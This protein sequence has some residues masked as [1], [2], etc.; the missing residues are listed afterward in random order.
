LTSTTNNQIPSSPNQVSDGIN[1][2]IAG[3]NGKLKQIEI[4]LAVPKTIEHLLRDKNSEG[5]DILLGRIVAILQGVDDVQRQN[6]AIALAGTLEI[7][8]QEEE[9]QRM[10][11]LLPA[12]QQSLHI[13]ADNDVA[14]E[15]CITAVTK[16]AVHLIRMGQYSAPR[17]ILV[18]INGPATRAAA[19][20][21]F[22]KLAAQA[23]DE[24][25]LQ[26]VMD[27]LL[28]EYLHGKEKQ[29]EAGRL[30]VAFDLQATDFL[31]DRLSLSDSKT[32]RLKLLKLIENIGEPAKGA[33][34]MVLKQTTPWY[35]TRNI[36][37]LL[38]ET[39][40]L[41]CFQDVIPYLEHDDFRVKQEVL[42]AAAKIGGSTRKQFLLKALKTVPP[43]LTGHVISLLGDIPDDSLVV[44]LAELLDKGCI[45]QSKCGTE[46]Q[47]TICEA[48]GKIGSI[49]AV[50]ILKKIIAHNTLPGMDTEDEEKSPILQAAQDALQLIR[51]D[52][53]QKI[54]QTRV[55]KV[56]GLQMAADDVSAKEAAI[57]RIAMTGDKKKALRKLFDLIR[58]CAENKDFQNAERLR[59][60]LYEI[61]PMAI[62]A[63]IQ[64]AEV[65]ERA[66][67]GVAGPGFLH[68]W[69]DMRNELTRQ[70]FSAIYHE[71]K[72]RSLQAEEILIKQGT[73]NNELFFINHGSIKVSYKQDDRE[74]FVKSL[75]AGEIA[76]ENFFNASVWTVNLR[77]LTPSRVSILERS[78]FSRWQEEFPGLTGK[79]EAFYK[80]SDN[81]Q[82]LLIQKGLSRRQFERYQLSRKV[83]IQLTDRRGRVIGRGF[84][85]ELS[86]ISRG[87]LALLIGMAAQENSR[88]LLGRDIQ[89]LIPVGGKP[90]YLHVRGRVQAVH[91]STP[92]HNNFL[93]HIV[94]HDELNQEAL[95]TILG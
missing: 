54:H 40:S 92:Q 8:V 38:G 82:D 27:K 61:S 80:R 2:L 62:N 41:D 46:L 22:N 37:R 36:I 85:G 1:R 60:R 48:L 17:I 70:E 25:A 57:I 81:V 31:M 6:A 21:Q 14:I 73:K 64:S 49:K 86:D 68:I 15:R 94:F 30:L 65:I 77:A 88:L 16:L 19:S 18:M 59:E 67:T 11:R 4:A 23:L 29:E 63:I 33:L 5:V 84:K 45:H 93:I 39:G 83:D 53:K 7:L 13:A 50:P 42:T 66:R 90:G 58:E 74:I 26:P 10:E 24:L 78:S 55:K 72:N 87:G 44:P 47:V 12:I 56:M 52:S 35:V 76:G 71:L 34:R 69:S 91:P 9:W 51:G 79:L 3:D 20:K 28:K 89:V 75:N 43:Q 32:E 95:Q